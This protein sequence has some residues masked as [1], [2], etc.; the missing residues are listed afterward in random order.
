MQITIRQAQPNEYNAI[1][2]LLA[3]HAL[4]I[5]DLDEKNI[6]LYVG[7]Y[8]DVIV[9]T[10]GVERYEKLALLRSLCVQDAYKHQGFGKQ[11]VHFVEANLE[12]IDALY[13][14]TTTAK[15]YFK[16]FGFVEVTREQTPEAIQQT[17]EFCSLCPS[18]ATI[19]CK[20]LRNE[21]DGHV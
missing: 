19:M 18:T 15:E 13:L 3:T 20:H 1:K 4:P 2:H 7:I 10:I 6:K 5:S 12:G 11:M 17:R 14:L 9:A 16:R 8:N 21:G